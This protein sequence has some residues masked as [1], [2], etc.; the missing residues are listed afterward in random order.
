MFKL[1]IDAGHGGSDNGASKFGYN[2]KDI[3]LVIGKRV[4]ELLSMYNPDITRSTDKTIEPE[5]RTPLIKDKYDYCISIHLNAAGGNGIEAIH[6]VQSIK[7]KQLAT[8]IVNK[9]KNYTGLPLRNTPVFSKVQSNGLDWYYMQRN[10][11]NTVTVTIEC[12]FLDNAENIKKLNVEQISQAIADGFKEFM[13]TQVTVPVVPPIVAP[14]IPVFK[15][16]L[17]TYSGYLKI[18]DIGESVKALQT[19]LKTLGYYNLAIDGS[20]GNG[21][22]IAVRSFQKI[23][24][25]VVDGFAGQGTVSKINELLNGNVI[26]PSDK[27][28]KYYKIGNAHIIETTPDNIDIKILGNTLDNVYGINGTFFDTP[29]PTL[30]NSCWAI[31]TNDG[32]AIGGNSMLVS[33][34][35]SIK[36]GT[37]VY[38]ADGNIEVLRV[39]SINEF[40]KP[41]KW[42]ISGYS[43]YPYM[44]FAAEKMSSGIDYKTAHTY[45]GYKGNKIYLIVKPYHMIK[46]ILPLVK[47]LNLDGCILLDGGGSSQLRHPSGSYKSTRK[48]NSAVLLKE[49]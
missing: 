30:P 17:L 31:A 43:V 49:I 21:T 5:A 25:L 40:K 42:S 46:D 14:P 48:I 15:P 36:R 9:I 44:G 22:D 32:H 29:N 8:F 37:I 6:S 28:S 33:Y 39:N 19:A 23:N 20:F 12:L 16:V 2:E 10:T 3:T 26:S 38:Y 47:E 13:E 4:Q 24:S 34:T 11:G 35:S 45:I 18:G 7:G 27:K 41:H 1:I